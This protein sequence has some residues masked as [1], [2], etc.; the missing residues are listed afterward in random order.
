VTFTPADQAIVRGDLDEHGLL[1]ALEACRAGVIEP[2][3]EADAA[4]EIADGRQF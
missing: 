3:P 4:G 1:E 2:V